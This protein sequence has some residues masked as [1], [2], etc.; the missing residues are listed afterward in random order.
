[1]SLKPRNIIQAAR[2][3][4]GRRARNV[5]R[6][7]GAPTPGHG[8]EV[9]TYA[10][11][12]PHVRQSKDEWELIERAWKRPDRAMLSTKRNTRLIYG[13]I[14]LLERALK[15]RGLNGGENDHSAHE[16]ARGAEGQALDNGDADL[17][18]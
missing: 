3:D 8:D 2:A 6:H 11:Y 4:I 7:K 9:E 1:M 18:S 14:A 15:I 13:D 17:R 16:R 10:F 5:R 12:A